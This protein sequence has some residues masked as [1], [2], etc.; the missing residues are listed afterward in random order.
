LI[1]ELYSITPDEIQIIDANM[2]L[3]KLSLSK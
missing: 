2:W 1:F 3:K